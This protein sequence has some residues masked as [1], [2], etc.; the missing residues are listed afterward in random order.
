VPVFSDDQHTAGAPLVRP[1]AR[2]PRTRLQT[3]VADDR[4]GAKRQQSGVNRPL[5]RPAPAL[6]AVDHDAVSARSPLRLRTSQAAFCRRG[7][8]SRV[9]FARFFVSARGW[10]VTLPAVLTSPSDPL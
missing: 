6:C 2:E 1:L 3:P 8:P 7:S 5:R 10:P 4:R 9:A